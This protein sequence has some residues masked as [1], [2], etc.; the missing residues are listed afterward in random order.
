MP[1]LSTPKQSDDEDKQSRVD[2]AVFRLVK[3]LAL[4][5]VSTSGRGLTQNE[6]SQQHEAD[7]PEGG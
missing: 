7:L 4:E 6:V 5:A 1:R 2:D 3:L